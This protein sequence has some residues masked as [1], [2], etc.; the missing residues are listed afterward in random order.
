MQELFRQFDSSDND[1]ILP[2]QLVSLLSAV[3]GR[4]LHRLGLE[5]FRESRHRL[6]KDWI[7]KCLQGG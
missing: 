7:L 6:K 5:S 4:R 3:R 2:T 1:S